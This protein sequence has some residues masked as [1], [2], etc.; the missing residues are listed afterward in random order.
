[1]SYTLNLFAKNFSYYD[2][3]KNA[4]ASRYKID[5][6]QTFIRHANIH[7]CD[8]V[9][10]SPI[11]FLIN[12]EFECLSRITVYIVHDVGLHYHKRILL[13]KAILLRLN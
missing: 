8:H 9:M 1:M 13:P 10:F 7:H 5:V 12:T 6:L 2:S 3:S 11:T 4:E